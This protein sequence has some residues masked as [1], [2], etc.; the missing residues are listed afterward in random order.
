[1]NSKTL[2]VDLIGFFLTMFIT[3]FETKRKENHMKCFFNQLLYKVHKVGIISSF[4]TDFKEK[5][6]RYEVP[7]GPSL[8]LHLR[9]TVHGSR[10]NTRLEL[11]DVN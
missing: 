6:R 9:E 2:I 4:A 5:F 7:T 1:M 3:T 8:R 11:I 10:V